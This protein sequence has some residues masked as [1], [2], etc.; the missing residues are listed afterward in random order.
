VREIEEEE[1]D[2]RERGID[3]RMSERQLFSFI[4]VIT[5]ETRN[6]CLGG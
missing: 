1:K 3:K 6:P 4:F 5:G 2:K